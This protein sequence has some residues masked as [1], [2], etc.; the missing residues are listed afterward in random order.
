MLRHG[1]VPHFF[2]SHISDLLY[3]HTLSPLFFSLMCKRSEY[4]TA[5]FACSL[6]PSW[7]II[8]IPSHFNDA[9]LVAFYSFID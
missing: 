2:S 1:G 5:A 4:R 7:R 8:F 3:K 9:F 6:K